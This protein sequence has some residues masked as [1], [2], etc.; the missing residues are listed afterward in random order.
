MKK[1]I[2]SVFLLVSIGL[3]AKEEIIVYIPDSMEWMN[4]L[5]VPFEE[6]NNVDVKFVKF[7][8]AN[9]ILTRLLLE[10][11]KPKA[12]VVLGLAQSTFAK[13]KKEGLLAQ[14]KPV[15]AEKIVENFVDKDYYGTLFDYGGLAIIYDSETMENPPKTFEEITKYED[16]LIIQDPRTSSTGQDFLLWTIALYGDEWQEFWRRLKPAIKTVTPGWSGSFGKLTA[17]EAPMMVSYA[18]NE[19]YSH[20]YY[21]GTKYLTIIPEEGGYVQV[22][23]SGLVNKKKINDLSK[24][25]IDFTLTDDFQKEIPLKNWMLPAT[26]VEL[27]KSFEHY[28][29]SEKY[30]SIENDKL[31]E[32]LE[33][34]LE[35]WEEIIKD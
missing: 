28:K 29:T 16:I 23:A 20:E 10:K 33:K 30:L 17:G 14:Y 21:G 18:S 24:K 22:E 5:V 31:V 9:T 15:G 11:R 1:L 3:F 2:L 7:E 34:W 12:D 4:E 8:G 13:A 32:N 19:A 27:P 25:F 6:E 26:S 35:E